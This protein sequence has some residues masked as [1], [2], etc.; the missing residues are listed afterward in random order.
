[1]DQ[2]D[3]GESEDTE[4]REREQDGDE[5]QRETDVAGHDRPASARVGKD[6]RN[7][8][9]VGTGECDIG[10]LHGRSRAGRAHRNAD[11][12]R[13][14]SRGVIDAVADH[15]RRLPLRSAADSLGLVRGE[16]LGMNLTNAG[17][18]GDGVGS[19]SVVTGEHHR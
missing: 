1:M 11:R 16:L 12:C 15:R 3:G 19:M 2:H 9:Q 7:Q 6:V 10:R 4:Q 5:R 18:G 14:Q 8:P 17:Q 13:G